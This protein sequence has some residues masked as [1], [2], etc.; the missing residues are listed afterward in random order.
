MCPK[1]D[2]LVYTPGEKFP[3]TYPHWPA[4]IAPNLYPIII[5][6]SIK[7]HIWMG[8]RD[9]LIPG[10]I[11]H[12]QIWAVSFGTRQPG[13]KRATGRGVGGAP[14]VAGP[15]GAAAGVREEASDGGVP[16]RSV[17]AYTRD[18]ASV[19]RHA[20]SSHTQRVLHHQAGGGVGTFVVPQVCLSFLTRHL[21]FRL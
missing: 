11:P 4:S 3:A 17:D 12:Q 6:M 18:A 9:C 21:R 13:R 1:Q 10:I 15:R 20:P 2:T 19:S 16:P 5:W 7:W 8:T 14:A